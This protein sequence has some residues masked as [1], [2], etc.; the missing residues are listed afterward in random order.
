[1]LLALPVIATG[2]VMGCLG[3]LAFREHVVFEDDELSSIT[4]IVRLVV[5]YPLVERC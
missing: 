2:D 4:A 3:V 5:T 1:M